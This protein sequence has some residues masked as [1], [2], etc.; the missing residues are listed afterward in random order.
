MENKNINR[1]D[2]NRLER[3]IILKSI[4]NNNAKETNKVDKL[5]KESK[6]NK[7]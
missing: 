4:L 5:I 6:Y 2:N 3:S 1:V 7:R